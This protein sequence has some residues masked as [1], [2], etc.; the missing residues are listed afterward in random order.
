MPCRTAW[1]WL[2][3][4]STAFDAGAGHRLVGR[5]DQALDPGRVVDRLERDHQ[6]HR[7]AVR[8]G[9]DALVGVERLRVD[10]GDDERDLG[11]AAP[12]GGVVDHDAP[13]ST[14]RGAHSREVVA[15]A[16]KIAMSKPWIVSS[17]SAWTISPP[18]SSR[19]A[20]RSEANGTISRAGKLAL[21]QLLEHHGADG[22]GGAHDGDAQAHGLKG[23]S[24]S[25]VVGAELE[26]LVQRAH[27]LRRRGRRCTTQEILI[28]E[29][30]IISMLMSS[31]PSVVNTF[32]ATPG[33]RLHAGADDRHLPH[34]RVLG[35]R[36]D[37][38]VGDHRVE[39][40]ARGRRGR[41]AGR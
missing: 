10:L 28:G 22:A 34:R 13:A 36:G 20:E 30:E 11:V 16:E 7:R 19:P 21:A 33:W 35:D 6:L 24:G 17:V 41:R 38:D 26:R 23:C 14:K 31:S 32:A 2:S 1:V 27:R 12:G 40:L 18:S 37:A 39:R 4:S 3:S 8:V 29:V 25:D 5:D 9:D 15:P